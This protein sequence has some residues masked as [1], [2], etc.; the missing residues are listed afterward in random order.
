MH[1]SPRKAFSA[2]LC[3][4]FHAKILK[5]PATAASMLISGAAVRLTV[6]S[7]VFFC[8]FLKSALSVDFLLSLQTKRM[9]ICQAVAA[10]AKIFFEW[11]RQ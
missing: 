8:G 3:F 1:I 11:S 4:T 2:V 10:S 9:L 7:S 5:T 6:T